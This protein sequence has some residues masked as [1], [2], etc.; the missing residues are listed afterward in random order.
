[1]K[2]RWRQNQEGRV[3]RMTAHAF[4]GPHKC[5]PTSAH[6]RIY[7]TLRKG[8][9]IAGERQGA[10]DTVRDYRRRDYTSPTR[11]RGRPR[12]FPRWRVGLVWAPGRCWPLLGGGSPDKAV[13]NNDAGMRPAAE[14]GGQVRYDPRSAALRRRCVPP[15]ATRSGHRL[16]CKKWGPLTCHINGICRMA[17]GKTTIPRK[18]VRGPTGQ[19]VSQAR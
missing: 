18:Y 16:E 9:T 19:S 12:G 1:M 5:A 3:A 13:A 11:E 10:G 17:R 15:L 7:G 8:M 14:S 6:C 2:L 4:H